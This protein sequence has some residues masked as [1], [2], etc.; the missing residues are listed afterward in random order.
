MNIQNLM[1]QAQKMQK[2]LTEKQKKLETQTF[3]GKSSLVEIEM[4]GAKKIQFVKIT[5]DLGLDKEDLEML[6][7]AMLLVVNNTISEIEKETE[8]MM[9]NMPGMF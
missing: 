5:N 2:D 9:P 1:K 4:N 7:D 8:K 6:E 3:K